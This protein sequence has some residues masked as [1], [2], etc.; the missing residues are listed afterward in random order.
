MTVDT[1]LSTQFIVPVLR[2]PDTDDAVATATALRDGGLG[3]V[4][5]TMSTPDVFT[6]VRRLTDD[7]VTVGVGTVTD[8]EDVHRAADAG[9]RFVVSFRCAPGFV[10]AA[11]ERELLSIPGALTPS[12]VHAAHTE[13]AGLI[14]LFPAGMITPGYLRELAPLVPGAGY[15]ISG[16]IRLDPE[17]LATWRDAGARAV[18]VGRDLGTC[19]EDGAAEVRRRAARA[20]E[21]VGGV[22][23]S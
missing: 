12:E 2:C 18:A 5:L 1:L 4:E 7:G 23:G 13:G 14:K 15:V 19:G 16:G 3:A 6:A 9:A 10:V 11:R 22:S 8:P 17:M 20:V 21:L